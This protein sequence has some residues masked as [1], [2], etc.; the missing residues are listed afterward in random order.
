MSP[1]KWALLLFYA[2]FLKVLF[3][4]KYSSVLQ[5]ILD[6]NILIPSPHACFLEGLLNFTVNI[7]PLVVLFSGGNNLFQS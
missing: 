5:G 3:F 1:F 7:T 2:S 4:S 6:R